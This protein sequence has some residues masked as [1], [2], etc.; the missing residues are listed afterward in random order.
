MLC[1]PCWDGAPAL[2]GFIAS[3]V[4][5]RPVPFTV[6]QSTAVALMMVPMKT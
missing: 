1:M 3:I 6:V 4:H 5:G 2:F